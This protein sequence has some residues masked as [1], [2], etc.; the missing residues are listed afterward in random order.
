MFT[1]APNDIFTSSYNERGINYIDSFLIDGVSATATG[2]RIIESTPYQ[3][4]IDYTP[5]GTSSHALTAIIG[6]SDKVYKFDSN[7]SK[8]FAVSG[9]LNPTNIVVGKDQSLFIS[10]KVDTITQL[11]SGGEKIQDINNIYSEQF[12]VSGI[13]T[14][15]GHPLFPI[16][17]FGWGPPADT[18]GV[19]QY[20][21]SGRDFHHI[22]GL[23]MDAYDNLLVVN[24]FEDNFEVIGQAMSG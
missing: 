4:Y 12:A 24:G 20:P 6:P 1:D 16:S 10:H 17:P 13:K 19:E 14:L 7:G 3:G 5:P 9:F 11:N 18:A 22:G 21:L 2:G 23:S 8:L 15:L